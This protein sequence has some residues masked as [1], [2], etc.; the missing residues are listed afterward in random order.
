MEDSESL[1]LSVDWEGVLGERLI[2]PELSRLIPAK[3][4]ENPI[5]KR[6]DKVAWRNFTEF[7]FD[8]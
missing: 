2:R 7:I 4:W 8:F 3:E 5:V 1:G 6:I